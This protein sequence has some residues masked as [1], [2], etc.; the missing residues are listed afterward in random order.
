MA[1]ISTIRPTP[2][3]PAQIPDKI[4]SLLKEVAKVLT[5]TNQEGYFVKHSATRPALQAVKNELLNMSQEALDKIDFNDVF[6][7]F[8]SRFIQLKKI[9]T[10]NPNSSENV[11]SSETS[12]DDE[13][14]A[15]YLSALAGVYQFGTGAVQYGAR[16]VSEAAQAVSGVVSERLPTAEE[17]TNRVTDGLQAAQGIAL[18]VSGRVA[19]RLQGR[20]PE[21]EMI[22][23]MIDARLA[24][25]R[26]HRAANKAA[27]K[28]EREFKRQQQKL[29]RE[30]AREARRNGLALPTVPTTTPTHTAAQ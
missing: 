8:E 3:Q 26:E 10:Q 17:V 21:D 23:D 14:S 25:K 11:T 13:Q 27:K 6:T 30:Q 18:D 9:S 1:A 2:T 28:Q 24:Q 19:D 12:L 5:S 29:A 22:Y 16:V 15:D 20:D 4:S 7:K